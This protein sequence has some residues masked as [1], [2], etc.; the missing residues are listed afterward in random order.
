MN[1][2]IRNNIKFINDLVVEIRNTLKA[3][4]CYIFEFHN[5]EYFSSRESRWKVSQAYESCDEGVSSQGNDF[6][7]VDVSMLWSSFE[8]FFS[9]L[10]DSLPNGI[11]VYKPNAPYCKDK[12]VCNPPKRMYIFKVS[13]I[14]NRFHKS[15]LERE[16]VKYMI[17][18]PILNEN[19]DVIGVIGIDYID[20][21]DFETLQ[22][23]FDFSFCNLCRA[24]DQIA[25]SWMLQRKKT[26]KVKKIK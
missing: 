4:R 10:E 7:D 25:Y 26:K 12:I 19:D 24:S 22:Y 13:D 11:S 5:G 1:Q 8:I 3:D 20:E 2:K 15:I 9:H 17:H 16:G 23:N 6:R 18:T 14:E 21:L